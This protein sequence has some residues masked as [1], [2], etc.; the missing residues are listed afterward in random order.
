VLQFASAFEHKAT[1]VE[2][3]TMAHDS[4]QSWRAVGYFVR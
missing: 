2:T 1:A 4:D 3:V